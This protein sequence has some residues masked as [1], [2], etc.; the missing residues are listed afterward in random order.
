MPSSSLSPSRFPFLL[1]LSVFCEG[2]LYASM[3]CTF[4]SSYALPSETDIVQNLFISSIMSS[5]RWYFTVYY[6]ETQYLSYVYSN[7][8]LNSITLS[9]RLPNTFLKPCLLPHISDHMSNNLTVARMHHRHRCCLFVSY[10]PMDECHLKRKS[11]VSWSVVRT[12]Q[13]LTKPSLCRN[14]VA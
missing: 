10:T 9:S 5:G 6:P 1:S 2:T 7:I 4:K 14:V 11:V 8:F 3:S 12:L 13:H